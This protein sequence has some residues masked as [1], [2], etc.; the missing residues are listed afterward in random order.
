MVHPL[1]FKHTIP[2][3]LLGER[4]WTADLKQNKHTLFFCNNLRIESLSSGMLNVE[5]G[6]TAKKSWKPERQ[7]VCPFCECDKF[8]TVMNGKFAT[9]RG[10]NL[11]FEGMEE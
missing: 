5:G 8:M 9:S 2:F 11:L 7:N 6:S 1:P 4:N 3:L 10:R